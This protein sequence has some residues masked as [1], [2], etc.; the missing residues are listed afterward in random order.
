MYFS[1][2]EKERKQENDVSLENLHHDC[3]HVM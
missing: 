3:S 1:I 2:K